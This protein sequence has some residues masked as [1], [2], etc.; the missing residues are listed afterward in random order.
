MTDQE[1]KRAVED[2]IAGMPKDVRA[3]LSQWAR[4]W[5]EL[6]DQAMIAAATQ[7]QKLV[8]HNRG[9]TMQ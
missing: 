8:Q 4:V 7:A 6:S 2:A 9:E 1:L 5:R 3:P